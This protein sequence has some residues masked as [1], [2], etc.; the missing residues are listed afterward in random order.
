MGERARERE[1]EREKQIFFDE[2]NFAVEFIYLTLDLFSHLT[3]YR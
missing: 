1:G 2:M 3:K